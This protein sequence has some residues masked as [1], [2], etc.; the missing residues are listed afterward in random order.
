MLARLL[1]PLTLALALF[2]LA[3]AAARAAATMET[4]I[5]D[6]AAVLEEPDA[7]LAAQA[8]ATWRALGIDDVRL[9]VHWERVSP[10]P[11]ERRVPAGFDLADHT[12]ARYDWRALDRAVAL[13]RDA[14][15][16]VTLAITGPGPL[17]ATASPAAGNRRLRPL[18]AL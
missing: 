18:P 10:R 2:A 5:A 15:M 14:G 6:D 16:T 17:W 9:L 13:V 8:V 11:G 1:R 12:D 3:P 7:G 4:G